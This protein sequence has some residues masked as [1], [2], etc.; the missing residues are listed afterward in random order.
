MYIY[1]HVDQ[2]Y[3]MIQVSLKIGRIGYCKLIVGLPVYH[4]IQLVKTATAG[5][6]YTIFYDPTFAHLCARFFAEMLRSHGPSREVP[7][8]TPKMERACREA[9]PT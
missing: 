5:C 9:G 3:G 1:Y 7:E 4:H 8:L 2:R 6:F